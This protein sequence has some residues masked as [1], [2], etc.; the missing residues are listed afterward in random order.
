MSARTFLA[1]DGRAG[2]CGAAYDERPA[3]ALSTLRCNARAIGWTAEP[4]KSGVR[5]FCPSCT[6]TR[7]RRTPQ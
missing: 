2:R 5:D 3:I 1:C 6:R 7:A 4:R